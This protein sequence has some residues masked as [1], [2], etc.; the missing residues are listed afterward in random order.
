MGR[1]FTS[2]SE[3]RNPSKQKSQATQTHR[4][5]DGGSKYLW[6]VINFYETTRRNI[7]SRQTPSH[8]PWF[9][10]TNKIMWRVQTMK[11][12]IF[13]SPLL[14]SSTSK[15]VPRHVVS[16]NPHVCSGLQ[17]KPCHVSDIEI[18]ILPSR[19]FQSMFF[20]ETWYSHGT[21]PFPQPDQRKEGR[22]YIS[23]L[24]EAGRGL[25]RGG[26]GVEWNTA[27]LQVT[28]GCCEKNGPEM[29]KMG[30]GKSLRKL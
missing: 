26:S 25:K 10:N 9:N 24:L 8:R 13:S 29:V 23:A 4:P 18:L 1:L 11:L 30:R 16:R 3:I 20:L 28:F 7:P 27:T 6:N 15:Y 5:D 14:T 12:L 17:V 22:V 2:R 19:I 21:K